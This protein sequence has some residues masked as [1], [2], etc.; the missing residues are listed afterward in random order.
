MNR[1]VELVKMSAIKSITADAQRRCTEDILD[2][3]DNV[4][5]GDQMMKLNKII[6]DELNKVQLHFKKEDIHYDYETENIHIVKEFFKAKSVQGLSKNTLFTYKRVYNSFFSYIHKHYT[7]ITS[8]DVR[9]F[10]DWYRN[11]NNCSNNTL[12]NVRKPLSSLFSW[13]HVN[14][15]IYKNPMTRIKKIKGQDKVKKPFT[16]FEIEK[17]R[18]AIKPTNFRLRAIFE[19]LLSSGIRV[20]ELERLN[21]TDLNFNNGTFKVL[22]KGNKERLAYFNDTAKVHLQKYL[23]TREDDD[24]ALFVTYSEPP[25]R[26][27]KYQYQKLIRYLGNKVGIR[28]HPHK[29]RR[30]MAT[31]AVDKGMPIEQ[32]QR[33]LGHES[34]STTM[35]YVNVDQDTVKMNHKKFTNY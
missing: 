4:L 7:L 11:V 20:G 34:I 24:P 22:G 21:R 10:L 33:L 12:D 1:R 18:D 29:F 19:L 2:K 9:D 27:A 5:D 17:M 26:M 35:I 16:D 30:T 13:M 3:M 23:M 32:V 6:N 14:D 8:D 15:Y 25:H 28:A 31:K